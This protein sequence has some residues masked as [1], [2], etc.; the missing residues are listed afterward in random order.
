MKA[1]KTHASR[2]QFI[3]GTS[4]I[5]TGLAIGFEF[6]VAIKSASAGTPEDPSASLASPEI[7][8]WVVVKP[9]DSV[10]VRIVRSEMGQGTITGLAQM[11]AEELECDWNKVTYEYPTPGESLKR[12]QVWGS[13]STGGSRGIRQ[14]EQY[15]RKG[16]AAARSML[17]QAAADQWG[18]PTQ[19]CMASN[20]VITHR[21]SGRQT[22]YGKV[23]LAASKLPV[24]KDVALKDPKDWKLIGKSIPRIDDMVGKVTGKQVY[25]IDFKLPGMLIA[26]INECPVF[27]E[28]VKSFDATLAM[29]VNGVKKVV[30]VGETAVAV[31]ADTFWHAKTAMEKV[32]IEWDEGANSKVNSAEIKGKLEEGLNADFAFVRNE[33][34]DMKSSLS[35]AT[36]K[37]ESTYFFPFLN[38]ATLEP[39]N[40]TARWTP[41]RCE[42]WVPTQNAQNTMAAVMRASGLTADQ[43]D[44]YKINIGGGFGRRGS[45]QDYTVQAVFIAKQMPGVPVKLIWTRE[46]DMTQGRYHPV[47]MGKLTATFDD[48]KNVTGLHMR[49]SGQSILASTSPSTL[50]A[51]KGLDP[52]VFQGL[53]VEGQHAFSYQF[54][55]LL[56][57]HAMR[58][59]HV[60]PGFWRGVNVNQNAIFLETF[61]DEMADYAGA[62]PLAFRLRYLSHS[63]RSM[64]VLNAVAKGIDW[65][66]PAPA[67]IYRGIAQMKSYGSYA[68]AACELSVLNG[69]QVKIH[70]IVAA[71]DPG[72]AVNPAQIERQTS[73]SFVF[74]LSA[75]FDEEI[76][77]K[78]GRVEQRNFTDYNS[79]RIS[80]MPKV[81]TIIIQGGGKEWGGI[82]EPTIAVAS[83]AVLN[84]I[85]RATGKRIREYPLK[86]SG[87]TLI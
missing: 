39:M 21:P 73:G 20:S 14:S 66:T 58:N 33:K 80:Q 63:P 25:G 55:N 45:H 11:V 76:T 26:T 50:D 57:D 38:H 82:G 16:G 30:A 68:A 79:M 51:N 87:F 52:E 83:P 29:Q 60:P 31:I 6:P 19:E 27:G 46:E 3:I 41:E 40:A 67:G 1:F 53:D 48:K 17:I 28:K 56:I 34:G 59:T 72:Y 36:K 49:L 75:L 35:N 62:D 32:K 7:G 5:A 12:K 13:F 43:C 65:T 64:A 54:Q 47:M 22:T 85:F 37:L 74:G 86:N 2:R 23:S 18:V 44:V 70:R 69:N 10:V 84:A 9:D 8:A 24:P 78:N 61:V 4:A 81:E 71:V 77:I 15:V 42:A